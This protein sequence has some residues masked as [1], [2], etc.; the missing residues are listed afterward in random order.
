MLQGVRRR[1]WD[2]LW[3][4]GPSAEGALKDTGP[5]A[6]APTRLLDRYSWLLR[7]L[8]MEHCG[9][10]R[11]WG[12]GGQKRWLNG[13]MSHWPQAVPALACH[14]KASQ[15]D[16]VRGLLGVIKGIQEG[17][18]LPGD[19]PPGSRASAG[20]PV[21]PA[22]QWQRLLSGCPIPSPFLRPSG[23]S[24]VS[25]ENGKEPA[26]LQGGRLLLDLAENNWPSNGVTAGK[27]TLFKNDNRKVPLNSL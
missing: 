19:P 4:G 14:L 25:T 2:L 7:L 3:V 10:L 6:S 22:E 9:F 21:P 1:D 26:G 20:H 23:L 12:G 15:A 5:S 16:W 17:A 18:D 27:S 11:P 8:R 13:S 24:F